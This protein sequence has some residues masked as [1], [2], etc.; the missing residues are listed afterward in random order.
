M[1]HESHKLPEEFPEDLEKLQALMADGAFAELAA[2][3]EKVNAE[4]IR[5]EHEEDHAS[6][7]YLEELKKKRL[8][9]LDQVAE[10]L[11]A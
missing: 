8:S 4:I 11:H 10:K 3:Y 1:F 6:D 9:M 2:E 7:H 5:I